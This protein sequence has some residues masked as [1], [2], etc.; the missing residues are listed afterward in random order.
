MHVILNN[1]LEKE[2]LEKGLSNDLKKKKGEK[3]SYWYNTFISVHH[4]LCQFIEV[5]FEERILENVY[6]EVV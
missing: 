6:E 2:L 3:I 1:I 4:L 5:A